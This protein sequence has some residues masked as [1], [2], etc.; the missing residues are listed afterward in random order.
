MENY[1]LFQVG[2]PYDM[3]YLVCF[4][5]HC[6]L[7]QV[8]AHHM[9]LGCNRTGYKPASSEDLVDLGQQSGKLGHFVNG[10]PLKFQRFGPLWNPLCTNAGVGW[11][12]KVEF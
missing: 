2:N 6:A 11:L 12:P 10:K 7:M 1:S 5:T 3:L 9:R 4:G 8:Q